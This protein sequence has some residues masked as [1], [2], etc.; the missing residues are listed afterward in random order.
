[1][2]Q[3]GPDETTVA[4]QA[5][6]AT[7]PQTH[8]KKKKKRKKGAAEGLLLRGTLEECPADVEKSEKIENQKASLSADDPGHFSRDDS[9]KRA[10]RVQSPI[11]RPRVWPPQL[12][13]DDWPLSQSS[14]VQKNYAVNE[15]FGS[16]SHRLPSGS[17]GSR[18]KKKSSK[19]KALASAG[20]Q[21]ETAGHGTS[22]A[23][24]PTGFMLAGEVMSEQYTVED[25]SDSSR[26]GFGTDS[27]SAAVDTAQAERGQDEVPAALPSWP[28]EKPARRP[29]R[30][31]LL[32]SNK[33]SPR[34]DSAD[35]ACTNSGARRSP[36]M[37]MSELVDEEERHMEGL[38]RPDS[39]MSYAQDDVF[40]LRGNQRDVMSASSRHDH[41][42]QLDLASL[43][44]LLV[45]QSMLSSSLSLSLST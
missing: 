38:T 2:H 40:K 28:A 31:K 29:G 3:S 26:K 23:A 41:S 4:V 14:R 17:E 45:F 1:M 32:G 34:V 44:P 22:N 7:T 33:V 25:N 5:S 42:V 35:G 9:V 24:S 36:S 15:P 43:P 6:S 20:H 27:D 37:S 18:R 10:R 30:S 16:R 21:R 11:R 19:K 12:L 39:D 8:K 13:D